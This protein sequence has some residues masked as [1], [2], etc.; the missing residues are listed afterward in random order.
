MVVDE[1]PMMHHSDI[2]FRFENIQWTQS[3]FDLHFDEATTR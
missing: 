3:R 2:P 1:D